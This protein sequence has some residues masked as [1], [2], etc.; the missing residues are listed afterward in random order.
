MPELMMLFFTGLFSYL[1]GSVTFG[2]LV[3]RMM[4]SSVDV[5]KQGSGSVGATNVLRTQGKL[6][7][8]IVLLGDVLKGLIAAWVGLW[9]AG[10]AGGCVAGLCA[11]IGHCFPVYFGFKGGKAVATA[12]GILLALFPQSMLVLLPV[13]LIVTAFSKIVSM[14]SLAATLSLLLCIVLFQPSFPASIYSVC[15][16]ILIVWKHRENIKR[17]ISGTE[18]KLSSSV[19]KTDEHESVS[20]AD[21]LESRVE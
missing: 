10:D 2:M 12:A 8:A 20:S 16:V 14:G 11:I 1:I 9:I 15:A 3:P 13:F 17:I 6:Q 7:A 19:K 5:R 21:K 4:G 18:N